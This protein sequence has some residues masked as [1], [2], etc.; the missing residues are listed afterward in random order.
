MDK[1]SVKGDKHTRTNSNYDN[2][3]GSRNNKDNTIH[4][5]LHD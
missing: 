3:N 5:F 4:S 2:A 1:D